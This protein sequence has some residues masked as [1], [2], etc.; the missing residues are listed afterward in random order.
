MK[1]S[2]LLVFIFIALFTSC[3]I[4]DDNYNNFYLEV[5]PIDSVEIPESFV[6]GET[7]QIDMTYT[8]PN[9]CYYFNDFIYEVDDQQRTI[10]VVNTVY[11]NLNNSC[12]EDAEAEEVTV[13][14]D[15]IVLSNETY[16]FKF[17]QGEDENGEDQF[18]LVEVPVESE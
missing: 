8:K 18:L 13:H 6:L 4:D 17:Y 5:I 9:G 12:E 10:A 11:T 2:A 3:S 1:K 15:F 16:V 7:Y 14:F